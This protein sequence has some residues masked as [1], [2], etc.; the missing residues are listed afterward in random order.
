MKSNILIQT[1][2]T[3]DYISSRTRWIKLRLF[4]SC[5]W[6]SRCCFFL[7]FLVQA[8]IP[9]I[10]YR[11]LKKDEFFVVVVIEF[12]IWLDKI[13]HLISD[14]I[15]EDGVVDAFNEIKIKIKFEY[16]RVVV[17]FNHKSLS[18]KDFCC[19]LVSSCSIFSL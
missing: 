13:C 12:T 2:L 4:F 15:V 3:T 10:Q 11:D 16:F 6:F 17:I 1:T 18:N 14:S 19:F 5:C 9:S 8:K 7:F